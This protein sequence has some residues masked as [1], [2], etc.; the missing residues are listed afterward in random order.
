MTLLETFLALTQPWRSVFAQQRT[1]LRAQRQALGALL[2]LGRATLS[3]IL[4]TNGRQQKSWSSE[5]FLH[6]R[7]RW[8]PQALFAPLLKEGLSFCPGRLLGVAVDDTRLR[9][10]GRCIPQAAYHRDP[11]SPPFHTNL[12]LGLRFLQ[13]SL[14]L[15]LHRS[16]P[17]SARAIPIRF[18]EV[19]T[20]KKPHR[21]APPEAWKQY[22]EDRKRF[23]LSQS[24]VQTMAQLRT[25]LDEAGGQ[26]KILVIAGDGSF[27][28]RTVLA[29][30]P[31]RTILIARARKDARLCFAAPT[32]SRR[33]YG[34]Q[35]F[36]PEQVRQNQNLPWKTT[37]IFYGGKRRKIRYKEVSQVLWQGG[38][39][40]RPLRL[41]VIAPT[42]YRKR[43]SVRLYYRQP[44][45]LLCTDLTRSSP[46]LLQIYFDRWQI[47]VNHRE[48]K[49]TLG[50]GQA[51]LW[52]PLAVPKQ[53]PLVVAAYSALL[54][55][56]LK[57]FGATR[58]TAYAELPKWRRSA[59]RPSC[60]DLITLLRREAAE[61]PELL[62]QLGIQSNSSQFVAAAAA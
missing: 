39:R 61:H 47:E 37:K 52:N 5:Y 20:V 6:S 34:E 62:K 26:G 46:Q 55:A 2:V 9:K 4:W 27:C 43:Q 14:L 40:T 53:P 49:D 35:K 3:R 22:Q 58:G 16:G 60:L 28:N 38:A 21:R 19:S 13:A 44:A 45:Y 30:I 12:M 32:G 18:E 57:V 51:Q 50:V 59:K 8:S 29:T 33:V 15:P 42:P 36:T 17:F 25:M 31:Q 54:L 1:W 24:F 7:A 10:S 48:E 11:L 56:A 41:F 23:N